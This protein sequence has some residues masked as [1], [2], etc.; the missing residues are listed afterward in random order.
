MEA[1][2]DRAS[3][4]SAGD[5]GP[6][7]PRTWRWR[8]WRA[9]ASV[10]FT[11]ILVCIVLG[12]LQAKL[13]YFPSRGYD[14]TP[15]DI[16]LSYEDLTLT[17][18]DG[19]EIAAW[20]VP[21]ATPRAT[22]LFSHGNAG[23][24]ADRLGTLQTFH[25]LG[26][27]VLIYDYR[28]Y[29]RSAGTPGEAGTYAD[30]AACWQHL[31]Q[32]LDLPPERIIL[33]GRSL[34]GAVAIELASRHAPGALIVESTFTSLVDVARRHYPLLPVDL[35]CVHRY[36]SDARVGRIRCP[37]LFLHGTEDQLVPIALGR[38]LYDAASAPKTFIETPGGHDEAG[39]EFDPETTARLDRWLAEALGE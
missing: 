36:E 25:R 34:G 1:N 39:F 19:V 5:S 30:A 31:T 14:F 29:G 8:V 26:L 24:M 20:Y 3:K 10:A 6:R 28:G 37:K 15:A 27:S 22:V 4:K 21:H 12:L 9:L 35:L 38:A 17:T 16:G 13:I 18:G 33:F 11:Y 23:N 2:P 7:R 32:R